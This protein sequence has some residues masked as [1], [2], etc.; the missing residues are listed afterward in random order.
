MAQV[1]MQPGAFPE[2]RSA[3]WFKLGAGLVQFADQMGLEKRKQAEA[4][5]I[6]SVNEQLA[7]LDKMAANSGYTR[8]ELLLQNKQ[9]FDR[10][11]GT[12]GMDKKN[13][14]ETYKWLGDHPQTPLEAYFQITRLDRGQGGQTKP[15][16]TTGQ[17]QAQ[18]QAPAAQ[19]P[20][21]GATPA[22]APAPGPVAQVQDPWMNAGA[23][24]PAAPR[25]DSA[26]GPEQVAQNPTPADTTQYA[27]GVV[28][29]PGGQNIT[30]QTYEQA[31][32]G[33]GTSYDNAAA[34]ARAE[35]NLAR[36]PQEV[37][38]YVDALG[39]TGGGQFQSDATRLK[40]PVTTPSFATDQ[41]AQA[42]Y[43]EGI[44][45]HN[46]AKAII[47]RQHPT[48]DLEKMTK[49]SL[50][51]EIEK[52]LPAA[53]QELLRSNAGPG[54]QGRDAGTGAVP[55]MPG[56]RNIPVGAGG[57][58]PAPAEGGSG[59]YQS[60]VYGM[61]FEPGG[62]GLAAMSQ[63]LGAENPRAAFALKKAGEALA[64]SSEAQAMSDPRSK[65]LA[66]RKAAE[67][68]DIV[69]RAVATGSLS[70]GDAAKLAE[71]P[72]GRNFLFSRLERQLADP[73]WRAAYTLLNPDAADVITALGT[74]FDP[75][76][77]EDLVAAAAG[78][79]EEFNLKLRKLEAEINKLGAE[80]AAATA[81][82]DLR[83]SQE[84]YYGVL[85]TAKKDPESPANKAA[86]S[87]LQSSYDVM[88]DIMKKKPKLED[89][90]SDPLFRSHYESVNKMR[91][92]LG[93]PAL[94]ALDEVKKTPGL[95]QGIMD[96]IG[97][98]ASFFVGKTTIGPPGEVQAPGL[99]APVA[100]AAQAPTSPD[101]VRAD[102]LASGYTPEQIDLLMGAE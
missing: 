79:E 15:Q 81:L 92:I 8:N 2:D 99:A 56:S 24:F 43:D 42:A 54:T 68:A 80:S 18:A 94:S 95:L 12:L 25:A 51:L 85:S 13:A 17:A 52:V 66:A 39:I 72:R 4:E 97:G 16:K 36:K 31:A 27:E 87:V 88:R 47:Q 59:E 62:A 44:K 33:A 30:A 48:W 6:Q 21:S 69:R 93:L 7:F 50:Q 101:K 55:A 61:Q 74:Q 46:A 40:L 3:D 49:N 71:T 77:K 38:N 83:K 20:V 100:P 91:G 9:L 65:V 34:K 10:L 22:P 89:Q 26:G 41:E 67:G 58:A 73:T 57:G 98:L 76:I 11:T 32:Q 29:A 45:L 1:I 14:E 53:K 19:T 64:A 37:Q 60:P 84:T 75:K 70:T 23:R 28:I 78:T 96:G 102:L 35:Q 5:R 63:R 82:R 90:V 86:L